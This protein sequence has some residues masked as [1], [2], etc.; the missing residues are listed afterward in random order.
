MEDVP[1][2][3]ANLKE[4]ER[5]LAGRASEKISAPIPPREGGR[6]NGKTRYP[7]GRISREDEKELPNL[8]R[9]RTCLGSC[10]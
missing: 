10:R 1:P 9:S 4:K 3:W 7:T 5:N 6:E 2:P 8:K